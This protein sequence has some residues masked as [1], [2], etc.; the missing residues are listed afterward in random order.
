MCP[1]DFLEF[2]SRDQLDIHL[3]TSHTRISTVDKEVTYAGGLESSSSMLSLGDSSPEPLTSTHEGLSAAMRHI[4][5]PKNPLSEIGE[6]SESRLLRITNSP[7]ICAVSEV[8]YKQLKLPNKGLSVFES[9]EKL[10]VDRMSNLLTL[11]LSSNYISS[12]LGVGQCINLRYLD[13]RK[14]IIEDLSPLQALTRITTLKASDNKIKDISPLGALDKLVKLKLN[15]NQIYS[16]ERTMK[17]LAGLPKLLNL[18][19]Q[20]NPCIAKVKDAGKK[21]LKGLN[22]EKLDKVIAEKPMQAKPPRE[23]I[24]LAR[25]KLAVGLKARNDLEMQKQVEDLRAENYSLKK[26]LS[27]VKEMIEKLEVSKVL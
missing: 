20:A 12:L 3:S 17:T 7:C 11:D 2:S 22:L 14:N 25:A 1:L 27:K 26:E 18:S 19:I 10:V 21:I 24:S 6:L 23:R 9:N 8:R 4:Q 15:N 5:L 13:L 16:F